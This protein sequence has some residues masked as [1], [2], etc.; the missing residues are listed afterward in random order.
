MRKL[1]P[2]LSAGVIAA[3][4]IIAPT[5]AASAATSAHTAAKHYTLTVTGN[6]KHAMVMWSAAKL[7]NIGSTPSGGTLHS[8]HEPWT[9]HVSAK[10]DVYSV[11]A[12]QKTG[13]VISC[14][15]RDSKGH[16][17]T[18]S[19]SH[20]KHGIATCIVSRV[21]LFSGTVAPQLN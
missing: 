10:N 1:L 8:A 15:I 21:D 6:G 17:L 20:G 18:R 14:T 16:V 19:T 2:T 3:A 12:T 9:K 11:V 5:T 7:S 13:T 4:L